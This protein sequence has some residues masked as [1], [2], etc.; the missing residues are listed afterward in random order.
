MPDVDRHS[1]IL[2][3]FLKWKTAFA[4]VSVYSWT[5]IHL[6]L[7]QKNRLKTLGPQPDTRP[8]IRPHARIGKKTPNSLQIGEELTSWMELALFFYLVLAVITSKV[9]EKA[10]PCNMSL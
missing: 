6:T 2:V 4:D 1:F 5:R 7:H 3:I 10:F 8:E 9:P